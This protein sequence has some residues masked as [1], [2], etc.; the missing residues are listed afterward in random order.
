MY[1]SGTYEFKSSQITK[2]LNYTLK[3]IQNKP[4]FN[5]N[6]TVPS[7]VEVSVAYSSFESIH[8][9]QNRIYPAY[10]VY[11]HIFSYNILLCSCKGRASRIN[12]LQRFLKINVSFIHLFLVL[13][14]VYLSTRKTKMATDGPQKAPFCHFNT[15]IY[16]V[17][18]VAS[19]S[20]LQTINFRPF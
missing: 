12:F 13:I 19:D 4:I 20:A 8:L 6:D 11:T 16:T 1:L 17:F 18:C 14:F 7:I 5:S 3:P 10:F 2:K 9:I 15:S